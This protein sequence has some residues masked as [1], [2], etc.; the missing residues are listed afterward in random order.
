M[1][2]SCQFFKLKKCLFLCPFYRHSHPTLSQASVLLTE[3]TFEL[4]VSV[5]DGV[6]TSYSRYF[7]AFLVDFLPFHVC[8]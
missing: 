7:D 2:F 8:I 6:F 5:T 1:C 4:N 3:L